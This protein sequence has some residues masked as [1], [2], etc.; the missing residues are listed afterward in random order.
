MQEIVLCTMKLLTM[1]AYELIKAVLFILVFELVWVIQDA[2]RFG[3]QL[4]VLNL[5]LK[6]DTYNINKNKKYRRK[7][8]IYTM[9]LRFSEF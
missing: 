1:I 8:K 7:Q 2:I 9:H 5:F 6:T 4:F 3:Q